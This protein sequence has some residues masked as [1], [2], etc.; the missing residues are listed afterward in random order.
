MRSEPQ[1][2]WDNRIFHDHSKNQTFHNGNPK[3]SEQTSCPR[4][5]PSKSS[6]WSGTMCSR[7]SLGRESHQLHSS[8]RMGS[9]YCTASTCGPRNCSSAQQC[10]NVS[11]SAVTV[12]RPLSRN[13][14]SDEYEWDW[15]HCLGMGKDPGTAYDTL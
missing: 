8:V 15:K 9:W 11:F 4:Y 2:E 7:N 6:L 5:S 10:S 3:Q 13:R 12:K 14:R 1:D